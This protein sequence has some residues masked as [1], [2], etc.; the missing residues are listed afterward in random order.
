M[1]QLIPTD[2]TF[3]VIFLYLLSSVLSLHVSGF[4]Q[5]IIRGI[6]SCCVYAATWFMQCYVV[7]LLVSALAV[8]F[9]VATT[10]Y[11]VVA[12]THQTADADTSRKT[13]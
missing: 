6:F 9:V 13:T 8:W 11:T 10:E 2:A 5:P 4:Y 3:F 7:F 12:T 1:Y